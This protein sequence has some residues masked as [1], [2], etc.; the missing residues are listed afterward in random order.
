MTSAT[1]RHEIL[2]LVEAAVGDGARRAAACAELGLHP[3]TLGRWR[4]PEG[5]LREDRRP[6]AERPIPAN[7]LS[8]VERQ[9]ILETCSLPEFASQPP[10][11][12][13]PRLADRGQWIASESSF[14][15]VLRAAGQNHRRGR[16]RRPSRAKP[17]RSFEASANNGE[18]LARMACDGAGVALLPVFI[19]AGHLRSGRLI[20]ILPEWTAPKL[21]LTLYYPPYQ[22]LPP[23]IAAFSTFFEQQI[24]PRVGG[25]QSRDG[26]HADIIRGSS[27]RGRGTA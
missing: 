23:R 21:W 3:R 6:I 27:P 11:Q 24:H 18:V 2:V 13:V 17:P 19:V 1:D 12:I 16:A 14:Y 9:R 10:S 8:E 26:A 25:E 15:R 22:S 7:R 5:G 20:E 4:D